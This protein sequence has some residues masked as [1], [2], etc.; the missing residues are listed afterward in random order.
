MTKSLLV[1]VAAALGAAG[2]GVQE[3]PAPALPPAPGH[4]QLLDTAAPAVVAIEAA[5]ADAVRHGSGFAISPDEVMTA[6][7]VTAGAHDVRVRFAGGRVV[8]ARVEGE[9]LCHDRA[10]LRLTGRPPMTILP[11]AGPGRVETDTG[12]DLLH[13]GFVAGKQPGRQP[14]STAPL[15]VADPD[16]REPGL[17][18]RMPPLEHLQR[19]DGGA[20]AAASGAPLIDRSGRVTGMLV[21]GDRDDRQTYAVGSGDLRLGL[22]GL[23]D[24]QWDSLGLRLVPIAE[25]D[26]RTRF[27]ADPDY[28]RYPG[29]GGLVERAIRRN[30][31]QGLYVSDVAVRAP[32]SGHVRPGTMITAV[33]GRR[34]RSVRA[35]CRAVESALPRGRLM[36]RGVTIDGGNQLEDVLSPWTSTVPTRR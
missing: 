27:A 10:L 17:P 28:G 15:T 14:M 31:A 4:Q 26:L 23:R 7:H 36:L 1:L 32:A 18:A 35:F 24:G 12:V 30:R 5:T 29:L 8:P 34:V 33:D 22:P 19:L 21:L 16:V 3:R 11:L 9:S 20:P 6:A 13:Y 2:C 25:I